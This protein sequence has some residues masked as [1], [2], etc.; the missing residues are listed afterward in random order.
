VKPL[1]LLVISLNRV[2]VISILGTFSRVL[3]H[4]RPDGTGRVVDSRGDHAM[5]TCTVRSMHIKVDELHLNFQR[6]SRTT[7]N[8]K[9]RVL[10]PGTI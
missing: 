2:H 4:K 8:N 7:M 10:S 3:P 6:M 5:C 1:L 9:D